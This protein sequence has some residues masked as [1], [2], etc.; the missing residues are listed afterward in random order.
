VRVLPPASI[1]ISTRS[2][3]MSCLL[4]WAPDDAVSFV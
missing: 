2:P 3:F 4:R 1:T